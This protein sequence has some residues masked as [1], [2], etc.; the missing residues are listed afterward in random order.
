MTDDGAISVS[1]F[2]QTSMP[3]VAQRAIVSKGVTL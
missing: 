1:A 2:G 3:Y